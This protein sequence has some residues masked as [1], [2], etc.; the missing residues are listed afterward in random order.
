MINSQI[1]RL[2]KRQSSLTSMMNH[3]MLKRLKAW[4]RARMM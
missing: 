2:L 4:T 1:H 3:T